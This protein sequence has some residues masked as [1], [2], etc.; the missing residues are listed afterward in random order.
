MAVP[1]DVMSTRVRNLRLLL[2]DVD[3]V[4]TDGTV[5]IASDGPESKRFD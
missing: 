1:E 3:G 4:L 2:F 5:E